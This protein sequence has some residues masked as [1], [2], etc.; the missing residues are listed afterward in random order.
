MKVT[1]AN[2]E[3]YRFYRQ[4]LEDV[5]SLR[6][7]VD[8]ARKMHVVPAGGT[9]WFVALFGRDSLIVSLQTAN[10]YPAFA[11]GTLVSRIVR[12]PMMMNF[13]RPTPSPCRSR[14]EYQVSSTKHGNGEYGA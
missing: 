3:Y 10:V 12:Q 8:T 2:E 4:S 9:P 5:A 14:R 7:P 1:A 11:R 13:G 6:L